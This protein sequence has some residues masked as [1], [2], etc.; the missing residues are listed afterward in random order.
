LLHVIAPPTPIFEI[1]SPM[2][3]QAE[4]ALS[5]LLAKLQTAAIE[6]RGFLLTSKNSIDGH[7]VGETRLESVAVIVMGRARPNRNCQIL[8]LRLDIQRSLHCIDHCR[9]IA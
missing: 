2:K 8:R 4:L 6:A 3:F 1:E 5:V 9:T 7:I